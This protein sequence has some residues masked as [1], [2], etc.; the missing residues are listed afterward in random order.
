MGNNDSKAKFDNDLLQNNEL[1][2]LGALSYAEEIGPSK[3]ILCPY[4]QEESRGN[5]MLEAEVIHTKTAVGVAHSNTGWV[6]IHLVEQE[7]P[8]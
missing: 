5:S 3:K 8:A 6:F 7:S 4:L 1:K 2:T